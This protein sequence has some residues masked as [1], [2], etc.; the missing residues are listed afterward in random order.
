MQG[1]LETLEE[2]RNLI[3][4]NILSE[5]NPDGLLAKPE[6]DYLRCLDLRHRSL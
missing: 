3:S 5:L 4:E 6:A 2:V 1:V